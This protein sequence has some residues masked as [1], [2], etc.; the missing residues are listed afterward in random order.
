MADQRP[1][2]NLAMKFAKFWQQIQFSMSKIIRII[3]I[4]PIFFSL[5]NMKLEAQRSLMTLFVK[6]HFWSTLFT[7]IGAKFQTLISNR[8][9]ICQR[10]FKV[11]K[12]YLPFN[13]SITDGVHRNENLVE[14]IP[15]FST[16]SN[17]NFKSGI[18][19]PK[20]F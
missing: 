20:T 2:R 10:P 11:R 8:G 17:F 7:K 12:C 4:I 15:V 6:C 14:I 9:L 3:R 19:L 5:K 16:F 1:I 13:P 18:D